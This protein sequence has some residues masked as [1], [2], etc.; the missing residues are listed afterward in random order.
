[1]TG[2]KPTSSLVSSSNTVVVLLSL[3]V[4]AD[5]GGD[6][7]LVMTGR[8]GKISPPRTSKAFKSYSV[9]RKTRGEGAC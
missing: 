7:V 2:E 5:A 4:A 6:I 1:M 3:A 9:L 8:R